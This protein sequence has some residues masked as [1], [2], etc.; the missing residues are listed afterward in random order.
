MIPYP[1]INHV[2]D[3]D[4][5]ILKLEFKCLLLLFLKTVTF[6][7]S[8]KVTSEKINC[9]IYYPGDTIRIFKQRLSE[10]KEKRP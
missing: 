1:I 10:T 6:E 8:I 4:F 2:N 7:W 9:N 3:L 5:L